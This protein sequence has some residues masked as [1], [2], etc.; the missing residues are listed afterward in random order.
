MMFPRPLDLRCSWKRAVGLRTEVIQV[1][2]KS[3]KPEEVS[4]K[5]VKPWLIISASQNAWSKENKGLVYK[6]TI[7]RFELSKDAD[8]K[9]MTSTLKN[10]I[11]KVTIP[12]K[13]NSRRSAESSGVDR[14][15]TKGGSDVSL[16]MLESAEGVPT[17]N[18]NANPGCGFPPK[19]LPA[20]EAKSHNHLSS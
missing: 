11:L 6:Q 2:L 4:V 1:E 18:V 5:V 16:T 15:M 19:I 3:F 10:C 14:D 7:R 20:W 8:V 9:A 12:I 13:K 17:D